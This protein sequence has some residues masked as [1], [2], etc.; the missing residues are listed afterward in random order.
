[1]HHPCIVAWYIADEPDSGRVP[2]ADRVAVMHKVKD[3]VGKT[4]TKRR[5]T[6]ACFDTTPA[7]FHGQ[8]NWID[9]LNATDI[10]MADIYED[11]P[12]G[13]PEGPF[14]WA[15]AEAIDQM[16]NA[17]AA[18]G[19]NQ[20]VMLVPRVFSGREC[21][22]NT[23]SPAA[24]RGQVYLAFIHGATGVNTTA[25]KRLFSLGCVLTP[26]GLCPDHEFCA[27]NCRA[28]EPLPTRCGLPWP[29]P[30]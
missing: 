15:V 21:Y 1:M 5:P 25:C 13:D 18:A 14:S 10:I 9:F 24:I 8:H 2:D 28:A 26:M 4:D 23:V 30:R 11:D 27:H 12:G 29:Q 19:N 22:S 7:Y 3:I 20:R 17:S 6:A 16:R